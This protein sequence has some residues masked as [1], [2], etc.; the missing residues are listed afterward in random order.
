MD[1]QAKK[2]RENEYALSLVVIEGSK[3]KKNTRLRK[4]CRLARPAV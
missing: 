1:A 4:E 2:E 3:R